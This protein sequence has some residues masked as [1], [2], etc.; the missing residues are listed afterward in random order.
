M[1]SARYF[2]H[3]N[4]LHDYIWETIFFLRGNFFGQN[5]KWPPYNPKCVKKKM[6]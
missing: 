5:S 4:M 2:G 6:E 3:F 1:H